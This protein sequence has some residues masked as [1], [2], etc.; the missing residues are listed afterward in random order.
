LA[1][2]LGV[3]GLEVAGGFWSGSLALLSDAGH[4]LTDAFALTLSLAT[5]W[6]TTRP[7][8]LKRTFGYYRFE[9][10][11]ALLNGAIL[12][13]ISVGIA[14]EAWH[15]FRSPPEIHALPMIAV[16]AL[17]LVINSSMF[18]I[19]RRSKSMNVRA[20]MLHV[21]SDAMSATG[22]IIAGCLLLLTGWRWVDPLTSV[23]IAAVIVYGAFRLIRDSVNVLLEAVPAHLDLADVF[24]AVQGIDGVVAVH[25]LHIWTLSSQ[26]YALSAHL[27]VR[28]AT[29]AENDAIL[30]R[31]QSL[32]CDR[33]NID[34]STLQI[35]SQ[36]YAHAR[37]AH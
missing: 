21:A 17:G 8:D 12:L 10:L 24:R 18:L 11:C 26:I 27:V 30:T 23:C 32:L 14:V 31:V 13:P 1:L 22:V 34:H 37:G 35:E 5:V 7:A 33:F 2:T 4:V 20:A 9:I 16:A 25:D 3:V 36:T 6:I 15:R 28:P 19:L 29:V